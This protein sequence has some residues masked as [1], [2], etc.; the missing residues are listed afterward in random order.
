MAGMGGQR[1]LQTVRRRGWIRL[2]PTDVYCLVP[3]D[4][5]SNMRDR[6]ERCRQLAEGLNDRDREILRQLA[7]EIEA[8]IRRL[9]KNEGGT[10]S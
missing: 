4:L 1:T 6:A 5:I 2:L 10:A 8:D 7:R 3:E 9:E